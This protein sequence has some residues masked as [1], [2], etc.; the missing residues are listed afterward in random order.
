MYTTYWKTIIYIYIYIELTECVPTAFYS[1][2]FE[3]A[4]PDNIKYINNCG[5]I[6]CFMP[7]LYNNYWACTGRKFVPFIEILLDVLYIHMQYKNNMCSVC[8]HK[9]YIQNILFVVAIN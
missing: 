1:H 4:T 5:S 7:E 2:Y 9:Q 3:L 8:T 6:S